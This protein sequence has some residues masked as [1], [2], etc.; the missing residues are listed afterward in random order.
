[1]DEKELQE[2]HRKFFKL[3]LEQGREAVEKAVFEHLNSL[4]QQSQPCS[5]GPPPISTP[6][7]KSDSLKKE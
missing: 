7:N 3:G 2:L 5:D 4:E 6:P 1:M